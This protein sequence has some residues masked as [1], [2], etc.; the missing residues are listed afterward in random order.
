MAE[1]TEEEKKDL[2]YTSGLCKDLHILLCGMNG[3]PGALTTINSKLDTVIENQRN[4]DK[5][6]HTLWG[7]L[8]AIAALF[9]AGVGAW[10]LS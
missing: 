6:V 4:T 7:A 10:Q 9:G 1:F 2:A 5:R 8:I 3:E